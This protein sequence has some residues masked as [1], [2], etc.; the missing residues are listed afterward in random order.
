MVVTDLALFQSTQTTT[1]ML[2][3][4]V[5][6]LFVSIGA[7]TPLLDELCTRAPHIADH[8]HNWCSDAAECDWDGVDCVPGERVFQ[9]RLRDV[10]LNFAL[11][12]DALSEQGVHTVG[13]RNCGL[14]GDLGAIGAIGSRSLDLS[15]NSGLFGMIPTEQLHQMVQLDL[16][17]CALSGNLADSLACESVESSLL[18]VFDVSSNALSGNMSV[19]EGS[20]T[21]LCKL[22]TLKLS[23]NELTGRAPVPPR[24][25]VYEVARNN[26]TSLEDVELSP[27]IIE[28]VTIFG[29]E[30]VPES[31]R[32]F[33]QS[34]DVRDNQFDTV[35]PGWLAN[36][37]AVDLNRTLDCGYLSTEE[38]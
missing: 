30:R 11:P 37:V 20:S 22:H 27:R 31:I 32:P 15:E 26:F 34:C 28:A 1:G 6:S 12:I 10:P 29:V 8:M 36:T 3:A 33:V 35:M 21:A 17:S 23:G 9:V 5:L 7:A 19:C 16:A 13:L 25:A 2:F 38:K 14:S 24:I 4:V 18:T